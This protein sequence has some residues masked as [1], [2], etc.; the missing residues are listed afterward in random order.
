VGEER[1][2]KTVLTRKDEEKRTL[3]IPKCS[4]EDSVPMNC[5]KI[6]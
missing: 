4:W 2:A 3:G 1:N 6:G 5:E